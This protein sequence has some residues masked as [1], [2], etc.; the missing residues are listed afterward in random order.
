ME[1]SYTVSEKDYL[2]A[3]RLR[4]K[5]LTAKTIIFWAFILLC[6]MLLW[7]VVSSQSTSRPAQNS[8]TSA[9]R[10]AGTPPAST[11]A[12]TGD[13][14][15]LLSPYRQWGLIAVVTIAVVLLTGGT[16]IPRL[17]RKDPL[18]RGQFTLNLTS[19]SVSFENTAGLSSRVAWGLYEYWKEGKDVLILGLKSGSY[20]I[21]SLANLSPAQRDELR[22]ILTAALPKK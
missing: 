12:P 9:A 13:T 20:F 21:V 4:N 3:W 6:L 1:F 11:S 16:T 8:Q 14:D 15:P 18:M 5:N 10:Q 7:S 22:S 2:R 17:Y 19:A